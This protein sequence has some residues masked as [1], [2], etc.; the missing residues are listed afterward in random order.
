MLEF[1]IN[2]LVESPVNNYVD[3]LCKYSIITL[4]DRIA[5]G[6]GNYIYLY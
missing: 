4:L 3:N 2:I 6:L 1:T 5:Q